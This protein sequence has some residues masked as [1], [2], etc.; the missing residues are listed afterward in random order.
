MTLTVWLLSSAWYPVDG[1]RVPGDQ[2]RDPHV[3]TRSLEILPAL[4]V[5]AGREVAG[6]H[7]VA[8]AI[9]LAP[10]SRR[11]RPQVDAD[12]RRAVVGLVAGRRPDLAVAHPIVVALIEH[13][14][15]EVEVDARRRA[16]SDASRRTPSCRSCRRRARAVP[17]ILPRD[18]RVIT[19]TTPPIADEPYTDDA[20][21]LSTSMRS[22]LSRRSVAEIGHAGRPA[23][24]EQQRALVDAGELRAEPADADAGEHA[25][26]L[27]DVDAGVLLEDVGE[28]RRHGA[29][30]VGRVD[31]LD[32]LRRLDDACFDPCGRSRRRPR[33]SRRPRGRSEAQAAIPLRGTVTRSDAATNSGSSTATVFVRARGDRHANA[34]SPSSSTCGRLARQR[35]DG[36]ARARQHAH[37]PDRRRRQTAPATAWARPTGTGDERDEAATA[38]Q[39]RDESSDWTRTMTV[40]PRARGPS[41]ATG[42]WRGKAAGGR[43]FQ[44]TLSVVAESRPQNPWV[45]LLARKERIVALPIRRPLHLPRLLGRVAIEAARL[46]SQWRDRAGFAPASLLCPRGHPRQNAIL[47]QR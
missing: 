20:A 34:P 24:D 30:D 46:H 13:R 22:T 18:W 44:C 12:A 3:L 17:P 25:R 16:A 14:A 8:A 28:V 19:L 40:P 38:V 42:M 35:R 1:Q 29:L 47:A 4:G 27:D 33:R 10:A 6:R 43:R 21:P 2:A 41:T 31:D 23:V 15:A 5:D 32:L 37:R 26:V 9:S 11:Q 7:D 36:H 39:S 45:G